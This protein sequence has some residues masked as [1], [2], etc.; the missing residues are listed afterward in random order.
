[1]K[2]LHRLF[3]LALVLIPLAA[4]AQSASPEISEVRVRG[5]LRVETSKILND[6]ETRSGIGYDVETVRNDIRTIYAMGLFDDVLV[7]FDDLGR[8]TFILLE[9]PALKGWMIEENEVLDAEDVEEEVTLERLEILKRGEIERAAEAIREKFREKGYYLAR[10][11]PAITIIEGGKNMV[12]IE[13]KIDTGEEVL[14]RHIN[15]PGVSEDDS[16]E[17]RGDMVLKERGS[18]SWLTQFGTYTAAELKRDR[19]WINVYYLQR[20]HADVRVG[21]P[22]TQV[23]ADLT[24]IEITIPVTPGPKYHLGKLTISGDSHLPERRSIRA[25]RLETGDLFDIREI[26]NAITTIEDLHANDGYA[27]AKVKPR[28]L[29]AEEGLL[30]D[31]EFVVTTGKVYRIGRVEASG[32]T[33]TRDRV[34][35]RDVTLA[36]GDVYSRAQI[37]RSIRKLTKLSFFDSLEFTPSERPGSDLVDI[38]IEVE[39]GATGTFSLGAGYSSVDKTFAIGSLE[40]TNLLGYG[41]QLKAEVATSSTRQ[42]YSVTFNNPRLFDSSIFTGVTV[43][44]THNE[45]DEYDKDAVGIALKIGT[46]FSDDWYTRLTYSFEN[47][48]IK[49]VCTEARFDAGECDDQVSFIVEQQEGEIDTSSITPLIAYDSRDRSIQPS[50]GNYSTYT[51]EV[52]GK[53]LGGDAAYLKHVLD[54]RQYLPLVLDTTLMFRARGGL[55]KGIDGKDIPIYERFALG[56]ISTLR[57]F[58]YREIGPVDPGE[59]DPVTG[60]VTRESSGEVIGGDKYSLFTVEFLFP[61]SDEAK[62]RGVF[63]YDAGDAWDLDEGWFS[64]GLRTSAGAGIRWFSPM[65]PLRLEYAINLDPRDG[66]DDHEWEFAIGGYF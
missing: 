5:N 1:M 32:N 35:R 53:Y 9:R 17:I 33:R 25:S 14:I 26:Q 49:D 42:T 65:G 3:C 36:E 44:R 55:I 19:E 58:D 16:G 61:I 40:E 39:E 28:Y 43:Y 20:G 63:F 2:I 24:A 38:N 37:K 45:Y 41:Y 48:D 60:E 50:R 21:E 30:M 15:L 64:S 31:L 6:I 10:V 11:E 8:L 62:L 46:S 12:E 4:F 18:W 66:E 47:A 59:T 23:S 52:A 51:L 7:E 34:I 57:G 29:K 56:G 22:L 13:F 54:S 27:F